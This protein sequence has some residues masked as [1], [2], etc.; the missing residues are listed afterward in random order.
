MQQYFCAVYDYVEK[1][2][3]SKGYQNPIGFYTSCS[4]ISQKLPQNLQKLP[5]S[6]SFHE[7]VAQKLL[8]INSKKSVSA[9]DE[10][11]SLHIYTSYLL[12]YIFLS[13]RWHFYTYR[14]DILASPPVY[15]ILSK[16]KIYTER[17]ILTAVKETKT[18][19]TKYVKQKNVWN[20]KLPDISV[21][22]T[23]LLQGLQK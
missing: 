2:D 6:C 11:K 4:D 18:Q 1:T 19:K 13:T 15:L 20:K 17:L 14:D 9:T 3:L 23:N 8:F 12:I 22:K 10:S 7:K 5:K 16:K 21:C